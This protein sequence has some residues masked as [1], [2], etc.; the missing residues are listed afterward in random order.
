MAESFVEK[1]LLERWEAWKRLGVL[2]S[3]ME[4]AALFVVGASLGVRTGAVFLSV[5][6]QERFDAGL[7][8]DKDETHDTERAIKVAIEAIRRDIAKKRG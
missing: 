4:A 8:S 3:E 2:A 7:D 6:N 5:W 1:E